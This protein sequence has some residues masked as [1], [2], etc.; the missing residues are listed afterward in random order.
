MSVAG[1]HRFDLSHSVVWTLLALLVESVVVL[2]PELAIPRAAGILTILTIAAIVSVVNIVIATEAVEEVRGGLAMLT[3][4]AVLMGEFVAFF[5]C[6][7][8]LLLFADTASFPGLSLDPLALLLASIM[9]FVFNPLVLPATEAGRA[10]LI[11]NTFGSLGL[12]LFVLQNIS[13][14]RRSAA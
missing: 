1:R 2:V 13:Q 5:A 8:G 4:L 14:F 10:L 11:I 6:Q 12:V 7:Y 9:A 3:T